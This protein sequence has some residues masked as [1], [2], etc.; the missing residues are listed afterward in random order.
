MAKQIEP[1]G[2]FGAKSADVVHSHPVEHAGL[3]RQH[4]LDLVREPQ[5]CI[6]GLRQDGPDA[7]PQPDLA[8]DLDV[9]DT[10]EPSKHLEF[11]ELGVVE[12]QCLRRLARGRGLGLATDATDAGSKVDRRL[13]PSWNSRESR[14]IWPSVIEIRL[15]GM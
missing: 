14:T 10:A 4:H 6:L 2:K 5:R 1:G 13:V 9:G 12:P 7:L 15:V 3:R 8:L 11:Q